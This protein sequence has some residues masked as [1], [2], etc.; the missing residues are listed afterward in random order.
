MSLSVQS[1][2]RITAKLLQVMIHDGFLVAE[3]SDRACV[4]DFINDQSTKEG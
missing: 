1:F 2:P 3:Q 4:A